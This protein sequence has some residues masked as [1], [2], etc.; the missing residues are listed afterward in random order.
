MGDDDD[1]DVFHHLCDHHEFSWISCWCLST[2]LSLPNFPCCLVDI[3]RN[4]SRNCRVCLFFRKFSH[5]GAFFS[6]YPAHSFFNHRVYVHRRWSAS[7][8]YLYI[9]IFLSDGINF[10]ALHQNHIDLDPKEMRYIGVCLQNWNRLICFWVLSYF[11]VFFFS[12]VIYSTRN[13]WR[14]A[15]NEYACGN[16]FS[17]FF[18]LS[19]S[20]SN[21]LEA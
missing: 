14:K 9:V 7:E 18:F 16:F 6:L 5:W 12:S 20:L 21:D 2:K 17:R 19:F 13:W 15:F 11:P 1:D 4:S 8:V 3:C 10:K